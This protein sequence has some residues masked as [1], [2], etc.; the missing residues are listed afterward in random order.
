MDE[1]HEHA[2]IPQSV[3]TKGPDGGRN[4]A[5][6]AVPPGS[7]GDAPCPWEG[8]PVSHAVL[9]LPG[10]D[11]SIIPVMEEEVQSCWPLGP[12]LPAR[13]SASSGAQWDEREAEETA[14][15][16][17]PK[18]TKGDAQDSSQGVACRLTLGTAES[19]AA[20]CSSGQVTDVHRT[21]AK[22]IPGDDAAGDPQQPGSEYHA[23]GLLRTKPGRGP[24]TACMSCSDKLARWNV[25]G[26]QGALLMHF[27]QQPIYLSAVVVGGQCP[28]SQEAMERALV[29]R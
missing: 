1:S 7:L 11:A 12:V 25:L 5:A 10:G 15:G 19:P 26:W 29:A 20:T 27:L 18:R 3:L 24:Q 21:G 4:G 6:G 17:L 2:C 8:L 9:F 14:A 23:V 28:Y 13:G 16:P 22:C